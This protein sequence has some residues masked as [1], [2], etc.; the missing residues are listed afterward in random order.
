MFLDEE[1]TKINTKLSFFLR[2]HRT[3]RSMLL[4]SHDML[5]TTDVLATRNI[6]KDTITVL[7]GEN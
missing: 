1:I 7:T 2:E 5:S 6:K 3:E 4:H